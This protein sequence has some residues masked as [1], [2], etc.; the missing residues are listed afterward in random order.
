MYTQY[1]PVHQT[2]ICANV[3]YLP[4]LLFTKYIVYMVCFSVECEYDCYNVCHDCIE[5][6]MYIHSGN[7]ETTNLGTP[8]TSLN[9]LS[10]MNGM[11]LLL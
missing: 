2:K 11:Y 10:G 5:T 4:N 3:H 7:K 9:D 6:I 1:C 8:L